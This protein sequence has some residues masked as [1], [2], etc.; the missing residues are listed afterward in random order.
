M[1]YQVFR[2]GMKQEIDEDTFNDMMEHLQQIEM[3]N[4]PIPEKSPETPF[5]RR[6]PDG[7]YDKRPLYRP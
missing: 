7:T 2:D 6:R 4:P 3:R 5:K 1:T